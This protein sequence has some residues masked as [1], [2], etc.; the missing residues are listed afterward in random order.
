M[1]ISPK[2]KKY[3]HTRTLTTMLTPK[4]L[5]KPIADCGHGA[6]HCAVFYGSTLLPRVKAEELHQSLKELPWGTAPDASQKGRVSRVQHVQIMFSMQ[7]KTGNF[8]SHL[9][10]YFSIPNIC[11]DL[12][13]L[14]RCAS[15]QRYRSLGEASLQFIRCGA[16]DAGESGQTRADGRDG[17]VNFKRRICRAQGLGRIESLPMSHIFPFLFLDVQILGNLHRKKSSRSLLNQDGQWQF[18]S[19]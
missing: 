9:T 8:Y 10:D 16:S 15:P 19:L 13:P 11:T 12:S 5:D 2:S 6:M 3:P 14:Q 18:L 7:R 4:I 1:I 17:H